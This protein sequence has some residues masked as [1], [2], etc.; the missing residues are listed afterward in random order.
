MNDEITEQL[1]DYLDGLL[2]DSARTALEARLAADPATRGELEAI[3]GMRREVQSL[4]RHVEPARDL[5]PDISARLES[6]GR[7]TID[8]GRLRSRGR[9]PIMRYIV[10]A[11]ALILFVLASPYLVGPERQVAPPENGGNLAAVLP[12]DPEFQRVAAQ[13]TQARDELFHLLELRK[14]DIAPETYAV[15]E[16][17]LAVIASAVTEI[18]TALAAQPQSEKLERMLYAAYRSEVNLLQ[19]AVQLTGM[20]EA[21][22]PA[23]ANGGDKDA[24]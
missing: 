21:S 5:W 19:Q 9:L 1:Y 10:A 17:N 6:A 13:Y 7:R 2:D 23:E 24:G 16:D 15:V 8:F 4:P 11:A 18:E 12:D 22:N 3:R 20:P 14:G